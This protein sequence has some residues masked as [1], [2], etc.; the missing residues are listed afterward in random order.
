MGGESAQTT[1]SNTSNSM[2]A[3]RLRLHRL[4]R[5]TRRAG[6]TLLPIGI[7]ALVILVEPAAAQ[8]D[9]SD[10]E[11]FNV[12]DRMHRALRNILYL[13]TPAVFLIGLGAW[14]LTKRN[15][16]Y[17]AIGQNI[18][19]KSLAAFGIALGIEVFFQAAAWVATAV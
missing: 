19:L 5:V 14:A 15:S 11:I 7:I 2:F 6:V 17:A 9:V 8:T 10:L 4:K 18:A 12:I 16:G 13:S 3:S 1:V